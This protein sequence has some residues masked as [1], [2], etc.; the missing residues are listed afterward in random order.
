MFLRTHRSLAFFGEKLSR[1]AGEKCCPYDQN[2]QP[3][4][5]SYIQNFLETAA[6]PIKFW[7]PDPSY[8]SLSHSWYFT[9]Y[10]QAMAFALAVAK[11]DTNNV[12][13]QSPSLHIFKQ[14]L[15]R[16]ELTTPTLKGLSNADLALAVQ[17][18]LIP[19]QQFNLTPIH[20][21]KNFRRELRMQKLLNK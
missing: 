1:K 8:T 21:E 11:L 12:L 18:S 14:E 2:G 9:N 15:L 4:S 16:I 10:L 5:Q 17:I 13:K 3:L 7:I 19:P 6:E 20:S